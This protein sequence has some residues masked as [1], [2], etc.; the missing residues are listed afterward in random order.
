[1]QYIHHK[2]HIHPA[3]Y[4]SKIRCPNNILQTLKRITVNDWAVV[5]SFLSL[6]SDTHTHSFTH[7][8]THSLACLFFYLESDI[9]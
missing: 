7:L 5:L 8:L 1:M 4:T 2:Q 3:F 9:L 6:A